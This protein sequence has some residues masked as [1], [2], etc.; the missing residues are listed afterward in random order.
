M[1]T[2]NLLLAALVAAPSLLSAEQKPAQPVDI[3]KEINKPVLV[4]NGQ[5]MTVGHLLA[6]RDTRQGIP[7][8]D[9]TIQAQDILINEL[10]SSM[11]L[12]QEAEKMGLDKNSQ[13]MAGIEVA[14]QQ[15]LR[16]VALNALIARE[17]ISDAAAME[18]YKATYSASE[19]REYKARHILVKEEADAK[20]V[21]GELDK[22]ADFAEL[23]KEKSTGPSGPLGGD[24][25]WFSLDRMVKP[26][27]D[28]VATMSKGSYTKTPVKTDFGW[29]VILLE[30]ER[31]EKAAPPA[32]DTVKQEIVQQLK[33]E[34]VRGYLE[35][36]QDSA[37]IEIPDESAIEAI[38]K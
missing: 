26:F 21:I 15:T 18:V 8:P 36:L 10:L 13:V 23:A 17:K 35:T 16:Q 7:L 1:N 38:E 3:E 25:G 2:K 12:A 29:H 19:S 32:F 30:D 22:G 33:I 6:Y 9:D 27:G 28:A 34:G 11:L 4:V 5:T 20:A 37:K 14:R 31:V 24:L